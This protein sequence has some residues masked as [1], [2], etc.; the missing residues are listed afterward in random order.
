MAGA[1]GTLAELLQDVSV[2]CAPIDAGQ[3]L[4]MLAELRSAKL[5]TGYRSSQPFDHT[6][7]VAGLLA[8]LS[9]LIAACPEIGEVEVNPLILRPDGVFAA[10]AVVT[11]A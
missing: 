4:D 5:L 1:G 6:Q 3:A 11:L 7:R 10:D 2:R 9:G 8:A